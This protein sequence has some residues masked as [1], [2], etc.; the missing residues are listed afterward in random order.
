MS[1][2]LLLSSTQ[3]RTNRDSYLTQHTFCLSIQTLQEIGTMVKRGVK[4]FLF[5]LNNDGYEI[6]RAIHGRE[7]KYNDIQVR[8]RR[9]FSPRAV[10]SSRIN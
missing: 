1:T 9:L 7:K 10:F 6:E 3:S 8:L 2:L 4:P 5:V